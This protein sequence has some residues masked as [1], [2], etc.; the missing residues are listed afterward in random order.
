MIFYSKVSGSAVF[1]R[2]VLVLRHYCN[3]ECQDRIL[4]N[5]FPG[6]AD[7]QRNAQFPVFECWR[8]C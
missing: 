1:C 2:F 5:K 3:S 8:H 4:S 7:V 6:L